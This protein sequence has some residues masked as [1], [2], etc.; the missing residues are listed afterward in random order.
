M[1][2]A[3]DCKSLMCPDTLAQIHACEAAL[4]ATCRKAAAEAALDARNA[5][6]RS[7]GSSRDKEES[8]DEDEDTGEC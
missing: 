1:K 3:V 7:P 6:Y 5:R 8:S 4:L 2:I